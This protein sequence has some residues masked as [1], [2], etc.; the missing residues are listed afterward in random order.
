MEATRALIMV[1]GRVELVCPMDPTAIDDHHDLC[2][3]VAEGRH[4]VMEILAQ[5]LGIK[6]TFR[7]LFRSSKAILAEPPEER[8]GR[9]QHGQLPTF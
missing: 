3:S 4:H 5:F 8:R 1:E 6:L 7:T 2:A 9:V